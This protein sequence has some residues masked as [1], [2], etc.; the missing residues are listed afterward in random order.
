MQAQSARVRVPHALQRG[1]RITGGRNPGAEL[2]RASTRGTV[3]GSPPRQI[4]D[5]GRTSGA[6]TRFSKD[7]GYSVGL[8]GLARLAAPW[9]S[10]PQQDESPGKGCVEGSRPS[11]TAMITRILAAAVAL[12]GLMVFITTEK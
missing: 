7:P 4:V 10:N 6:L 9:S 8:A 5:R 3:V 2:G 11:P 12:V 1:N